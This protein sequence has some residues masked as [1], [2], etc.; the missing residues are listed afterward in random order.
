MQIND[1]P[2]NNISTTTTTNF[3]LHLFSVLLHLKKKK[4]QNQPMNKLHNALSLHL[5]TVVL[6]VLKLSG[7]I[8]N[9]ARLLESAVFYFNGLQKCMKS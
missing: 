1:Y 3:F 5:S 6:H 2:E 8:F 9:Y 7:K 4:G